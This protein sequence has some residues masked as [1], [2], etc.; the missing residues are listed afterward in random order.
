VETM[1]ERTT[2]T[3]DPSAIDQAISNAIGIVDQ[4]ISNA[5]ATAAAAAET[6][7]AVMAVVKLPVHPV[8]HKQP[9]PDAKSYAETKAD[10]AKRG[11]EIPVVTYRGQVIDGV[12]RQDICFEL[13]IKPSIRELEGDW[14]D[15]QLEALS[16]SLNVHRR[17]LSQQQKNELINSELSAH[18]EQSDR[19]VAKKLHVS[20]ST[21]AA[22]RAT[23]D[24]VSNLDTS[25]PRKGRDG[26]RYRRHKKAPPKAEQTINSKPVVDTPIS[27]NAEDRGHLAAAKPQSRRRWKSTPS[28]R[29]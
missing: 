7:T 28:C 12:T 20:P 4:A 25:K 9:R 11:L 22:K 15:A 17:H 5:T 16:Q 29:P 24:Q 27:G 19:S 3:I 14:S 10:I 18:P 1:E 23:R 26:K 6:K 21:V 8:A 13:G 2:E